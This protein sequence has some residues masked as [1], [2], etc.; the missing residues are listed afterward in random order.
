M[1]TSELSGNPDEMLGGVT[2][3]W[4]PIQGR[5]VILVIIQCHRNW[6]KL[7]CMDL[8]APVQTCL[9][10]NLLTFSDRRS[11]RKMSPLRTEPFILSIKCSMF[12]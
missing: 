10:V 7:G 8:L 11:Y 1:G 12:F 6:D 2:L 3:R 5:V 4:H 9:L